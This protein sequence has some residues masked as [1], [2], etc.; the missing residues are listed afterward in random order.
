VTDCV[1]S[2]VAPEAEVISDNLKVANKTMFSVRNGQKPKKKRFSDLNVIITDGV[3]KIC[4]QRETYR[5]NNRDSALEVLYFVNIPR[6][7]Y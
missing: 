4:F 3:F 7:C 1:L 5:D 6:R 2:E